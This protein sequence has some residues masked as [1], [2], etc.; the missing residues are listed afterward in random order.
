[1][2]MDVARSAARLGSEEVKIL[3]RGVRASEH[4]LTAALEEGVELIQ[5]RVFKEISLEGKGI[6][7]V[8]CLKAEV[9]EVVDGK[10]QFKE[11]PG[12]EHIVPGD[13]VIWALGQRIDTSLKG[14]KQA[15]KIQIDA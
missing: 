5:G 10:R 13:L 4:E 12:T 1:M 11:L 3:C 7:G 15:P 9:G 6:A 14:A 8:S 2:A